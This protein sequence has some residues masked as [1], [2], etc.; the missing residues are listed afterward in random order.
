MFARRSNTIAPGLK[1]ICPRLINFRIDETV[2]LVE[3]L[4]QTGQEERKYLTSYKK[5]TILFS[6]SINYSSDVKF[7]IFENS[8][9]LILGKNGAI[10]RLK[11][12]NVMQ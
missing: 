8:C 12:Y 10:I 2:M 7:L 9:F 1:M 5:F 6:L 3:T 4:S 11:N